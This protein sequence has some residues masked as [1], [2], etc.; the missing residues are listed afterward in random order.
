MNIAINVVITLPDEIGALCK[1]VNKEGNNNGYVSFDED[2]V[3]HIT[4]GMSGVLESD[5]DSLYIDII[6]NMSTLPESLL[7][8]GFDIGKYTS[9]KIGK[10]QELQKLH[11]SIMSVLEKYRIEE[12]SFNEIFELESH[13]SIVDWVNQFST[14]SAFENY[15]PHI[16]LTKEY[17]TSDSGMVFPISFTPKNISIFHLGKHGTCKKLL[18]EI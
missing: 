6:N 4:L 18:I 14:N 9:F 12:V 5:L 13:S 10:S 15:D 1:E 16:T 7:V 11:E 8:E 3:P 17:S 2:Y